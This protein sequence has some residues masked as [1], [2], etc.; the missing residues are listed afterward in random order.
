MANEG[1]AMSIVCG[2]FLTYIKKSIKKTS[3]MSTGFFDV[4]WQLFC[5]LYFRLDPPCFRH[6]VFR[7]MTPHIQQAACLFV[8]S[9]RTHAR[10]LGQDNPSCW[11]SPICDQSGLNN[12]LS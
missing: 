11:T 10:I 12:L 3:Q 2:L 6:Q 7:L 1:G 8:L 5:L 4:P 9:N